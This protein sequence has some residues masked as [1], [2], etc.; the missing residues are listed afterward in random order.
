MSYEKKKTR[1]MVSKGRAYIMSTYNNTL[2]TVTDE[3]GDVISWSS[4]GASGF[5]GSKKSTPY[6]AQVAATTAI[7]K[8]KALGLAEVEVFVKGVGGGRE[9]AIRSIETA[10]VRVNSISDI[11]PIPHGG[12]RSKKPRRV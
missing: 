2:V 5:K 1:K 7:E 8:A 11:T 3:F 10:G 6:A 12:C 4:S 9:Q